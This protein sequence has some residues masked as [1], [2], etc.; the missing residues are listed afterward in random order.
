MV[1]PP[2][3]VICTALS[4]TPKVVSICTR[5][6]RRASNSML[7]VISFDIEAGGT[8]WL[9]FLSISTVWVVTS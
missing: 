8:G 4:E 1:E 5:P 6:S 7:I 9:A 2:A 3:L